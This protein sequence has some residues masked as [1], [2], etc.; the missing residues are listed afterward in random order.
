MELSL[1]CEILEV[2]TE[3]D[4]SGTTDLARCNF[5]LEFSR[6]GDLIREFVNQYQRVRKLRKDE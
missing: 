2:L 6:T 4:G 5:G 1:T 3:G